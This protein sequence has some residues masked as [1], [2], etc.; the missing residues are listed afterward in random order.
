M[1]A[2]TARKI[3]APLPGVE[4]NRQG[5]ELSTLEYFRD[6]ANNLPVVLAVATAD[7]SKFL[8]VNRAYEEVWGRAVESLYA[9]SMSFLNAVHP[10]DQGPL[11][12][13]LQGLIRGEPIREMECRLIRDDGTT[14]CVLCRGFPVRD[15]DG[16]VV[17]LVGTAQDITQLKSVENAVRE[18]EDRYRD[19][20][21]HS[22]DLLCTH[23]L[24][25][26]ILSVNEAPLK[27]LGY[28]REDLLGKPLRDFVI[29]EAQALCDLYLAQ[30]QKDGFAKGL[31]P[32]QTK[33]GEVRL[34]EYNNS[35]REEGVSSPIVRGL[36]HDVTDQ[37]NVEAALRKSEEKFSKA[38]RASPVEMV[39]TTLESDRLIDFNESF[40]KSTGMSREALLGRTT[41]EL[42]M[43]TSA[44]ERAAVVE[45][46]RRDGRVLKREIQVHM[47]PG[48]TSFK[49]FSA[50]PIRLGGEQCLIVVSEDITERKKAEQDVQ[51]LSSRLLRLHDKERRN[52]ARDLHDSTG[53]D[54]TGLSALLIQIQDQIPASN[55]KARK[56]VSQALAVAEHCIRDVR[57]LSYVL[58]PAM[59]EET[60]LKDAISY[61]IKGYTKR[62]RI[63]VDLEISPHF[64]RLNRDVEL[65]LFRVVQESLTNIHRH[66]GSGLAK[67]RL[68]RLPGTVS[69]EISDQ[70]QG[71]PGLEGK[72]TPRHLMSHGVGLF[73]MAERIKQ[74]GGHFEVDS[75][76]SGT[77]VRGVIPINEETA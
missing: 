43:W 20:V 66:S 77:T 71:I 10:E 60:G 65:A 52:I 48:E 16:H 49:L 70:G 37:K 44:T 67:V 14:S 63:K 15:A 11:R 47:R 13:G 25:G 12:E 23:D 59:L 31:L 32:V 7:L 38:F 26:N 30:I 6:I 75:S 1:T 45:D 36:A 42:G 72:V 28:A 24:Q 74:V 9:D 27:I 62:T 57:T 73:S 41:L 4:G 3:R 51:R 40:E 39:I 69:L 33:S 55:R 34:W 21:E 50:E 61:Y 18:S 58:H 29:P 68:K 17:R 2:R 8:F 46:I 76:S 19:L 54:L 35:L 64:G 22:N 53:Q 56:T 5:S